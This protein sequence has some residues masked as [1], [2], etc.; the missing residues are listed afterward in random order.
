MHNKHSSHSK[1]SQAPSVR[2]ITATSDDER[3]R[4]VAEAAYF[5]AQRRAFQGGDINDDWY[6]AEAEID[7]MLAKMKPP[8]H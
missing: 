1:P 7:A 4:M 2:N 8:G 3:R 6:R 5:R